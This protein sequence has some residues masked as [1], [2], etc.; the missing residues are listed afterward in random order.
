MEV[1]MRIRRN[2]LAPA[3]LTL[4]T[5]GSLV[6]GPV[7]ALTTTAAPATAAVAV[8]AT[9]NAKIFW[10][11]PFWR[12][13]ATTWDPFVPVRPARQAAPSNRNIDQLLSISA[14]ESTDLLC[15]TEHMHVFSHLRSAVPPAPWCP[16]LGRPAL[17]PVP[18]TC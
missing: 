5:V 6:A 7:L 16:A 3:I 15:I 10:R 4:G 2:I 18:L 12:V 1:V 13:A 8:G 14:V 11:L 9:P 17:P